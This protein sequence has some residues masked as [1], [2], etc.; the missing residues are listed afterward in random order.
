VHLSR[1]HFLAGATL[2]DEGDGDVLLRHGPHH[3]VEATH[4]RRRIIGAKTTSEC[5]FADFMAPNGSRTDRT[6]SPMRFASDRSGVSP[7]VS[8]RFDSGTGTHGASARHDRTA[9]D[10]EAGTL[11][12]DEELR[13]DLGRRGVCDERFDALYPEDVRLSRASSGRP[14]C[15]GPPA[16]LFAERRVRRVLDVVPVPES[17]AG[18]GGPGTHLSFSGSSSARTS[19]MPRRDG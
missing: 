14:S 7:S 19:S 8:V 12:P 18:R 17:S 15:R 6:L 4:R 5:R 2:A 1:E 13:R 10:L 9:R 16:E 3:P 11:T